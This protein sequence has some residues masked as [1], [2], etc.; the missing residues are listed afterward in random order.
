MRM[1]EQFGFAE[2]TNSSTKKQF[3]LTYYRFKPINGQR[4]K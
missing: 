4:M 2:E 3:F 1:R